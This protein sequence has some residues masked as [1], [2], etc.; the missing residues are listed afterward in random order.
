MAV[1]GYRRGHQR[2]TGVGRPN[3]PV[4]GI[5]GAILPDR[6]FLSFYLRPKENQ[7][8]PN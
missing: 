7:I 2:F 5:I 1:I 8:I 4:V 3:D 6:F